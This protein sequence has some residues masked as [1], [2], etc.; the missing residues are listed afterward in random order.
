MREMGK[1]ETEDF[2]E[3]EHLGPRKRFQE[4]NDHLAEIW[5][6]SLANDKNLQY[7]ERKDDEL[8]EIAS[9]QYSS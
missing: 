8:D 5:N 2:E 3:I 7:Q 1:I 4:I 9:S 6:V